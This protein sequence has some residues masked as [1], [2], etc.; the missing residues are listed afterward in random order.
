MAA[1]RKKS[2]RSATTARRRKPASALAL[3]RA[4]H[5]EVQEMFDKFE[6]RHK[7][8]SASQKQDLAAKI[9]TALT[10]HAQIEEEIFYPAVRE[11]FPKLADLLEEATVEHGT[12]KDL[13][14]QIEEGDAE[15][16]HFDAMVT[17]L[18]EYIKHHVKE[19]HNE[20]FPQLSDRKIDLQ[21]LGERLEARKQQ[22]MSDE[23]ARMPGERHAH[24]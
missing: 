10:V 15:E 12:A 13:I 16:D 20:L 9:C 23:R 1:T 17:V 6:S 24:L 4:D 19:E 8:M 5:R 7:R 18:G 2:T 22:L 14:A 11:A 3:L 21:E